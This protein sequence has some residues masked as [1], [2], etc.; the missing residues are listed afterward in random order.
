[1]QT[2]LIDK[3]IEIL[4]PILITAFSAG[5]VDED[6]YEKIKKQL[7]LTKTEIEVLKFEN[8]YHLEMISLLESQLEFYQ[9]AE[10]CMPVTGGIYKGE[11]YCPLDCNYWVPLTE[12]KNHC[13]TGCKLNWDFPV[14]KK[15]LNV[16]IFEKTS[17]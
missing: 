14:C 6:L 10:Y 1:M 13:R 15:P 2:Y 3:I 12:R 11:N 7:E 5:I 16:Q 4:L 17:D 9:T 8:E